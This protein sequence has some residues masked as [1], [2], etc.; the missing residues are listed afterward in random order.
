MAWEKGVIT[1]FCKKYGSALLKDYER[2]FF[3]SF[4]DKL[5]VLLRKII[6]A[7]NPH[8]LETGNKWPG[9]PM[10]LDVEIIYAIQWM[11]SNFTSR[12]GAQGNAR[13]KALCS[14]SNFPM[15]EISEGFTCTN[16]HKLQFYHHIL[17]LKFNE[18]LGLAFIVIHKLFTFRKNI[19]R[20]VWC[21]LDSHL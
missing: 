5:H 10:S 15:Q 4:E 12:V 13:E 3:H 19:V 17:L 20:I 21:V 18:F 2:S 14:S 9:Y 6:K 1:V 11:I 7:H 8:S 16:M